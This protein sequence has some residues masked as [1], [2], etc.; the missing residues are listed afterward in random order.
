M[1]KHSTSQEKRNT[2][3]FLPCN[4]LKIPITSWLLEANYVLTMFWLANWQGALTHPML[5]LPLLHPSSQKEL[6]WNPD[7]RC[8]FTMTFS[9]CWPSW[10]S[11]FV[12]IYRGGSRIFLR[13][14]APLRNDVTDGE[15][16][17]I[18]KANT[19]L[20]RRKFHLRGGGRCTPPAPSP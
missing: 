13:R 16:K 7:K 6:A 4:G 1:V 19:Y 8:C 18:L 10:W 9:W 5:F 3:L 12:G 11:H 17:Q 14:G 2:R 20:R 15:V